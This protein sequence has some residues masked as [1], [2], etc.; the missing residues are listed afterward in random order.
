MSFP[1]TENLAQPPFPECSQGLSFKHKNIGKVP[2]TYVIP[3]SKSPYLHREKCENELPALC[4][5]D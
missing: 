2:V 4:E 5:S 1:P 3:T